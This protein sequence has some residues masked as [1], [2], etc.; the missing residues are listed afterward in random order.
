MKLA[1]L[2]FVGVTEFCCFLSE[3][4]GGEHFGFLGRESG[5]L[6]PLWWNNKNKGLIQGYVFI[7]KILPSPQWPWFLLFSLKPQTKTY[8]KVH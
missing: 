4:G 8:L 6:S 7:H 1:I 3:R 5:L 2:E